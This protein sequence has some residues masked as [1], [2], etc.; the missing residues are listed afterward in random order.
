MLG[1]NLKNVE[2]LFS[3]SDPFYEISR[4]LNAAGGQTWDNVYRSEPVQNNL[5]PD[6]K[7]AVIDLSILCEGNLDQPIK[8]SVYDHESKG[9]HTPMGDLEVRDK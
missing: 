6:W 4:R 2:G 7:D 3:K 5:N 8:I 1:K 9:D